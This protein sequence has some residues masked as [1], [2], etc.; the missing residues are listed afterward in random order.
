M[1]VRGKE[2]LHFLWSLIDRLVPGQTS[3][4]KYAN[5]SGRCIIMP[6]AKLMMADLFHSALVTKLSIG[7]PDN[8]SF[9]KVVLVILM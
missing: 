5:L 4:H 2:S 1:P 6:F 9:R 7:T 8:H 3:L